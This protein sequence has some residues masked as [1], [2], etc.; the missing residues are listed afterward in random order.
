MSKNTC[1]KCNTEDNTND[2]IWIDSDDFKPFKNDNWDSTKH[3]NATEIL[4]YSALCFNCYKEECC[5]KKEITIY[6]SERDLQELSM[7]QIFQLILLIIFQLML[8]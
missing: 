7:I 1:D 2:L 3:Q 8:A 4:S 5:I 6:F